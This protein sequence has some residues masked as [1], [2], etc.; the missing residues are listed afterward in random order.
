M[1][2]YSATTA[3]PYENLDRA[4][5]GLRAMLRARLAVGELADWTSLSVTGPVESIDGR[6]HRWFDYQ[7]EVATRPA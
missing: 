2:T 3:L 7:A 5:S 1:P 4:T 6:G